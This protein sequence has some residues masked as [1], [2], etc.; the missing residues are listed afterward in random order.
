MGTAPR[1]WYRYDSL[2]P[3]LPTAQTD[4]SFL[5]NPDDEAVPRSRVCGLKRRARVRNVYGRALFACR[6]GSEKFSATLTS[7]A[8]ESARIFRITWLQRNKGGLFGLKTELAA[9]RRP[10]ALTWFPFPRTT[11]LLPVVDFDEQ[12]HTSRNACATRR[13]S[14]RAEYRVKSAASS[15]PPTVVADLP[16]RICLLVSRP[17]YNS[18]LA[19]RSGR[20]V[21]PFRAIPAN[22][23]RARE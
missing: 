12:N 21:A 4:Q 15:V 8:S 18:A 16:L 9:G 5:N 11:T 13:Y 1:L 14:L 19:S 6:L 3:S 10:G 17:P 7:S 22:T 2:T 20:R 23:P